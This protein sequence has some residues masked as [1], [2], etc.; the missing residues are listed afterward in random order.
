MRVVYLFLLGAI[1]AV[2][3]FLRNCVDRKVEKITGKEIVREDEEYLGSWA[4]KSKE[5]YISFRLRRDGAFNYSM[6]KYPATDTNK[7]IGKYELLSPTG[8]ANYFPRLCTFKDN[9]DTLFNYYIRYISPYNS[10]DKYSKM[11]FNPN[12]VFDT[13]EY[14]FYRIKQ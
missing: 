13:I 7:I 12:S 14:V 2:F 10:T 8:N 6:V 11:V 3:L 5:S 9:G 1:V 4:S